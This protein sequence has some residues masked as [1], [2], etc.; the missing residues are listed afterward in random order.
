MRSH[1]DVIRTARL[2]WE[3][4]LETLLCGVVLLFETRSLSII[5]TICDNQFTQLINSRDKRT[6]EYRGDSE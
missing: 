5:I 4:R 6:Q 3:D 1:L 2:E